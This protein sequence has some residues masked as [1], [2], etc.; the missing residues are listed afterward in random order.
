MDVVGVSGMEMLSKIESRM[1][2]DVIPLSGDVQ[3]CLDAVLR[4]FCFSIFEIGFLNS[5]YCESRCVLLF[6]PLDPGQ[7]RC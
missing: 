5:R 7:V 4:S 6:L 1:A 3:R 2:Y